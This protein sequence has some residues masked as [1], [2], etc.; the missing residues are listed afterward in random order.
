[1]YVSNGI[2]TCANKS[3]PRSVVLYTKASKDL[4]SLF[5]SCTYTCILETTVYDAVHAHKMMCEPHTC[6]HYR[7]PKPYNIFFGEVYS[8][9][10]AAN[11]KVQVM[12][13]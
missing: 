7:P 2:A 12:H 5:S 6:D 3:M 1:M 10:M 11:P 9:V 13:T 8:T 4:L